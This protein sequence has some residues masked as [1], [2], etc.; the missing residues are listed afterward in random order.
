MKSSLLLLLNNSEIR[1]TEQLAD[2]MGTTIAMVEAQLAHYEHL[3][4]VKKTIMGGSDCGHDCKKCHG[5][6]ETGSSKP[7]V[8]WEKLS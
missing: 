4:Y 2:A 7:V 5:C 1:S 8:F 6:N 3:G